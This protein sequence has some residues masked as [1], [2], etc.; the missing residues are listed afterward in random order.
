MSLRDKL[1][2]R[3]GRTTLAK[4]CKKKLKEIA[5]KYCCLLRVEDERE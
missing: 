3:R 4:I 1:W 2:K 5:E